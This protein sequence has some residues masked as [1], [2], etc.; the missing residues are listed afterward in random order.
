MKQICIAMISLLMML[1]GDVVAGQNAPPPSTITGSG[2]TNYIPVWIGSTTLGSSNLYQSGG[3]TGIGTVSPKYALDVSGHINSSSGYLVGE[4]L[5]LTLPGGASSANLAVGYQALLNSSGGTYN[6]AIGADALQSNATGVENTAVGAGALESNIGSQNTALGQGALG[7]NTNGTEN[8]ATGY[9]ALGSSVSG[10]FNTAVGWNALGANT[11]GTNNVAIGFEA[12]GSVSSGNSNNIH[13]GSVGASA[14]SGAIRIGTSGTQTFF[15]VAGVRG[16]T[17]SDNNAVPVVI[18][19][20]GQLGTVSS[21]RRFKTDIEDMGD[22]SRN[23]MRLRPVTFHYKR[24]FAD[25]SQPIQ[26]GLIAEEVAEVFPDLVAHSADGQI[27][28]VKYQLLEPML[29][30]EVQR[31]QAEIRALEDRLNRIESALAQSV[32]GARA[33]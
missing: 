3:D 26:Y 7:Y 12:A 30:N 5:V 4:S 9:G 8:T 6:T 28:T 21:S 17:T 23:L 10:N 22:A 14:D 29:L 32:A 33:K 20:N 19:S 15:F 11:S 13:I 1:G 24:P 25:G 2:T 27:E 16:V 18:D 31:Q